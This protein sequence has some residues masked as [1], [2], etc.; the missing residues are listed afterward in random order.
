MSEPEFSLHRRERHRHDFSCFLE[1]E[2]AEVPLFDNLRLARI[3]RL[4]PGERF[5]E[6]CECIGLSVGC[7]QI[8]IP[9]NDLRAAAPPLRSSSTGSINEQATHD[10]RGHGEKMR[11][12][13]EARLP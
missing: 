13:L 9:L 5:V 11:T 4:E 12:V 7:D 2:P 6:I 3:D 8:V 10:A 1:R